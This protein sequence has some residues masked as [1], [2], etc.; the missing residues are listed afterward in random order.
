MLYGPLLY[1]C[2]SSKA[3]SFL[4]VLLLFTTL[5]C[6]KLKPEAKHVHLEATRLPPSITEVAE[7]HGTITVWGHAVQRNGKVGSGGKGGKRLRG[8]YDGMGR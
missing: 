4:T 3:N 7:V 5:C 8:R 2:H 1:M 6:V